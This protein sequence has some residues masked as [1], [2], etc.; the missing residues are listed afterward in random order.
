MRIDEWEG[1]T[2]FA[3]DQWYEEFTSGVNGG[4]AAEVIRRSDV[5]HRHH[6]GIRSLS[7]GLV[8]YREN[9]SEDS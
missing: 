2:C 7:V 1:L 3:D 9:R 5:G 6:E 8:W 4:R